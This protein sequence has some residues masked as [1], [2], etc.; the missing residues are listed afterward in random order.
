M[1]SQ[2]HICAL[3]LLV[4]NFTHHIMFKGEINKTEK[5]EIIA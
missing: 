5:H 4:N 1:Y 3:F 2:S